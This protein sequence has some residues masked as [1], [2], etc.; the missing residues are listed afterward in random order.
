MC[1]ASQKGNDDR[2]DTVAILEFQG[3]RMLTQ[4]DALIILQGRVENWLKTSRPWLV[5]IWRIRKK[6]G[7]ER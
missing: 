3:E 6:R 4:F 1:L 5:S 7:L 2:V